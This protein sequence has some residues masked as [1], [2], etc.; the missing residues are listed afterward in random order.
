MGRAERQRLAPRHPVGTS[1]TP[2]TRDPGSLLQRP[3]RGPTAGRGRRRDL[4]ASRDTLAP[5][6]AVP[7][8]L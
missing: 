7:C 1:L 8:L 2:Q 5:F 6:S 3:V 4:T